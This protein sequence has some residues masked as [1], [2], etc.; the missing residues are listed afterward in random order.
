[1]S[2]INHDSKYY[3]QYCISIWYDSDCGIMVFISL[4]ELLP[5]AREYGKHHHSMYGLISGMIVMAIS[6]LLFI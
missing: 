6:L 3:G 1:M 2:C 5:C 4:D